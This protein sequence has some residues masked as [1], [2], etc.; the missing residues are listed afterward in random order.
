MMIPPEYPVPTRRL[1]GCQNREHC[2]NND[3]WLRFSMMTPIDSILIKEYRVFVD[4]DAPPPHMCTCILPSD[5]AIEANPLGDFDLR[6]VCLVPGSTADILR[7]GQRQ[8]DKEEALVQQEL[9]RA[10][11]KAAEERLYIAQRGLH[12]SRV[13]QAMSENDAEARECL[14]RCHR[15]SPDS[16]LYDARR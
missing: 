13:A 10:Q 4:N 7:E 9:L 1:T 8:C 11:E 6:Y 16:C 5:V 12:I 3:R 2:T 15:H 14:W